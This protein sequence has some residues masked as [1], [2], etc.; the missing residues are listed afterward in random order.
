M[1][2]SWPWLQHFRSRFT[3]SISFFLNY[4]RVNF[5]FNII[6]I[7][8]GSHKSTS[9]K[10]IFGPVSKASFSSWAGWWDF[11]KVVA[12]RLVIFIKSGC[13]G[14]W[15]K[16]FWFWRIKLGVADLCGGRHSYAHLLIWKYN[17]LYLILYNKRE[18]V[19]FK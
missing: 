2:F 14:E 11:V 5:S 16:L 9:S 17:I 4:L 1:F 13:F 12:K 19:L 6:F 7:R 8:G 15:I 10:V 18:I 3:E